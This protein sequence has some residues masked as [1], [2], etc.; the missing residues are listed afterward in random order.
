MGTKKVVVVCAYMKPLTQFVVDYIQG[1][2]VTVNDYVALEIPDNLAVGAQEPGKLLGIYKRL[3]YR[4]ADAIV[5]SACVQMPSLA[6]IEPVKRESG[7]PVISAAVCTAFRMLK[8]LNLPAHAP[9]AGA[10]S[11]GRY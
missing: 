5:L 2:G 11:S 10:L 1:E 6:A 8:P 9:D 7:I 3:D 4:G